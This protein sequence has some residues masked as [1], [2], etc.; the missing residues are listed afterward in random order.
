MDVGHLKDFL[1]HRHDMIWI[2]K[3]L[4]Y[5][6]K[7]A[8]CLVKAQKNKLYFTNGE[9]RQSSYIEW[10]AQSFGY[11][12]ANR[13]KDLG[14]KK[15]LHNAFLVGITNAHFSKEKIKDEMEILIDVKL[16]RVVGPISF[17][18]GKVYSEMTKNIYCEATLKV[19][20]N[21]N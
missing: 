14:Q 3:V 13:L 15:S 1:P 11:A 2:D 18:E 16:L 6:S 21:E 10:I 12:D 5:T 19:F 7:S 17:I 20:S 4:T 8:T 9:I